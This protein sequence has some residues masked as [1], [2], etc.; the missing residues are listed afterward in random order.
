MAYFLLA[1]SNRTNLE[2]C[3]RHAVAGFTDSISGVWAFSDIREDDYVSFLYGARAFNLYR[4]SSKVAYNDA[5]TLPPWPPVTF[6]RTYFFPFRLSLTPIRL[7]SESL[8]RPEFA[9]VAE[10][11]LLRGGYRKTHFQADQTTLQAVSQM[12]RVSDR[13]PTPLEMKAFRT[14]RPAFTF[15]RNLATPPE[16]FPFSELI[17]QAVIRKHLSGPT[18]LADFMAGAGIGQ[19]SPD[20]LEALGERAFP[21][22]HVDILIKE[23]VPI[24]TA[25]QIVVE[26]KSQ[27]ASTRDVDQL[28]WYRQLVGPEC[29]GVTLIARRFGKR[30]ISD[31][32]SR[33]ITLAT[34]DFREPQSE[35]PYDFEDLVDRFELSFLA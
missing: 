16:T 10:N 27:S 31:A 30:V 32:K 15:Q 2:L 33:G 4:V 28:A 34:Y 1:V 8:V 26:V 14:I 20:A 3:L 12:G 5:S 13:R 21:E 18:G 22:G 25:R 9:Y 7:F 24:G 35:G 23:A 11:L 17:L 6:R 29:L 19:I